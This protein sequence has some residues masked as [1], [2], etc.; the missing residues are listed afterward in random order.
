MLDSLR[1]LGSSIPGKILMAFLLVGLAG[2]GISGVLTSIGSNTIAKVGDQEITIR[3]FQRAYSNQLNAIAQSQGA[4]PTSEQAVAMGIPM[5]VL[6]SLAA[7]AALDAL[8]SRMGLGASDDQLATILRGTTAFA[9]VD[10]T[11]DRAIFQR[12]LQSAGYTETEYLKVMREQINRQQIVSTTLSDV[13]L[14]ETMLDIINRYSGD[15]RTISYYVLRPVN[16]TTPAEPT[17]EEMAAYLKDNQQSFRTA[18]TRTAKFMVLDIA[19]LA[20]TISVSDDAVAAEYEKNKD[21]YAVAETRTIRQVIL[22]DEN[23]ALFEKGLADGKSFDDMVAETGLSAS[24]LGTLSR[25][26]ITDQTLVDTAF[27][28]AE[29]GYAIVPGVIGNRAI[30][31][32][33]VNPAHT[34]S[35]DE[36]KDAITQSLTEKAAKNTFADVLDQI[37][38]LRAAFRPLDEIASR[39][40]LDVTEV[41]LT[42]AGSELSAIPA[43]PAESDARV[44]STVFSTEMGTLAPSITLASNL[45]VWFDLENVED[46]RDQTLDEVR[47]TIKSTMLAARTDAILQA[48][49]DD[50]VTAIKGGMPFDLAATSRGTFAVPS[51]AFS[52]N[53]LANSEIDNSIASA[54]FDGPVDTIGA[55]RN[56]SG[57]YVVFSVASV[58]PPSSTPSQQAKDYVASGWRNDIYSAFVAGLRSDSGMRIAQNTLAQQIGLN[59]K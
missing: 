45:S 37:E 30:E 29:G 5:S 31:V 27:T 50:D 48:A 51:E 14:P 49:A 35:L 41:K 58:T 17:E 12:A 18:P 59:S 46:A 19:S 6:N 8:G 43:I 9:G 57:N 53:G 4:V 34:K 11:F 26:D 47:D 56:A 36:V 23:K 54:A 24:E 39:F 28:L 15:R 42:S 7:S 16:V 2:F 33:K 44:A 3:D 25:D 38:E 55:A 13:V 21:S 32:S 10:G 40:G 52:R 1:K 20:K 22:N